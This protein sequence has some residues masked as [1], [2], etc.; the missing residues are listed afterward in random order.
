[1]KINA[2]QGQSTN[3]VDILINEAYGRP[4]YLKNR[5]GD[6]EGYDDFDG[7][8]GEPDEVNVNPDLNVSDD[9]LEKWGEYSSG[10]F[11]GHVLVNGSYIVD[12]DKFGEEYN[13]VK[14]HDPDLAKELLNAFM[15]EVNKNYWEDIDWDD[16][17]R[18]L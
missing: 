6:P 10:D 5:P 4:I 15:Y 7:Y 9:I 8:E 11:D 18:H 12:D 14:K 13:E 1:M 2:Y 16:Y 17:L 3:L